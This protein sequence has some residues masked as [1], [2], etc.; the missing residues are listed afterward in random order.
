[1]DNAKDMLLA[2]A[3][4]TAIEAER[5]LIMYRGMNMALCIL[6]AFLSI[7]VLAG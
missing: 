6:C 5:K 4:Q 3:I 2:D 7:I 1:M